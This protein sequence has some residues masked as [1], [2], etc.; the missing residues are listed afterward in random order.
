MPGFKDP[1]TKANVRRASIFRSG[2][3]FGFQDPLR[4]L[5]LVGPLH[6]LRQA[7]VDLLARLSAEYDTAKARLLAWAQAGLDR[8]DQ[9][10]NPCGDLVNWPLEYQHNA[11]AICLP[12]CAPVAR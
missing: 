3:V 11:A 8:I 2:G 5:P 1:T 4:W 6:A 12:D 9:D 10:G 7:S